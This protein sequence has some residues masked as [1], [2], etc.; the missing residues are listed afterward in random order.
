MW[1]LFILFVFP[2]WNSKD[3]FK[4]W[5]VWVHHLNWF[6]IELRLCLFFRLNFSGWDL[7]GLEKLQIHFS[8]LG[9]IIWVLVDAS[10]ASFSRRFPLMI[11]LRCQSLAIVLLQ[12]VIPGVTVHLYTLLSQSCYIRV[13]RIC[14]DGSSSYLSITLSLH[15]DIIVCILYVFSVIDEFVSIWSWRKILIWK[16]GGVLTA[17][18]RFDLPIWC[19]R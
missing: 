6:L 16:Y 13:Y 14:I 5:L 11:C 9:F 3:W 12:R 2:D 7:L 4:H 15:I 1:R 17:F 18:R 19:R 10:L 8:H